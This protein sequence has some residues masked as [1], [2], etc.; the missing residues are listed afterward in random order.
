MSAQSRQYH[1]DNTIECRRKIKIRRNLLRDSIHTRLGGKCVG[2]G[3]QDRRALQIDHKHGGGCLELREFNSTHKY[4]KMLLALTDLTERYQ[5]LCANCNW[6]KR[7]TN[8]EFP[9]KT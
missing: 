7:D 5:L 9:H 8:N 3:F 1:K 4:Y 6:I 2:C